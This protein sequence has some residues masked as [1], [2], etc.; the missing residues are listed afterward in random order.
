MQVKKKKKRKRNA[1]D[2][3]TDEQV[4]WPLTRATYASPRK[5]TLHRSFALL[6][7]VRL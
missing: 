3:L 2:D 5:L 1:A 6:N 4:G 7:S